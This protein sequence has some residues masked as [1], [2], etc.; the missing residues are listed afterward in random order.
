MI[1]TLIRNSWK[2]LGRDRGA[3]VLAFVVPIAFFSIF[4]VIFGPRGSSVTSTSRIAVAVADESD[5]PRSRALVSALTA[6]SGLKVVTVWAGRRAPSGAPGEKM[7]RALGEQ[8]VKSGEVS[9]AL[10]LPAGIDSSILSFGGGRAKALLLH[11]PSDPVASRMVGGLLQRA[12][13]R[14]GGAGL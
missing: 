14:V 4:A 5:T 10:V 1:A 9:V 12:A 8:L 2:Q 11:D 6:D 7:T 13:L 3:Q